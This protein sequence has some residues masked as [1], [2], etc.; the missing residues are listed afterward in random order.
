MENELS[1]E[2]ARVLAELMPK[3][4]ASVWRELAET[5]ETK[6]GGCHFGLGLY[7][8]NHV[9]TPESKL[10]GLFV[11]SGVTEKDDMSAELIRRWHRVFSP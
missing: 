3:I 6:L 5:P 4:S 1:A 2:A 8:R 10:Y 9:L 11:F 7:L